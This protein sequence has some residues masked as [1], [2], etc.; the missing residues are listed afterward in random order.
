MAQDTCFYLRSQWELLAMEKMHSDLL[1]GEQLSEFR[2]VEAMVN[3]YCQRHHRCQS[4]LCTCCKT[5]LEY[6]QVRLDRCSYGQH[7][8]TCNRCPIHCYKPEPKEQMRLVMRYAGP[9][10]LLSHPI[11]AIRH[12]LHEK[13][14]LPEKP[15][16]HASNRHQRLNRAPCDKI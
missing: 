11:L 1:T 6:A 12:L 3:I 10:M 16:A 7:K 2:T 13:R 5:L 15:K 4:G 9:R 8:P 14:A